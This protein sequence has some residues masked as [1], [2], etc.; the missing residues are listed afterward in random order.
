MA[1][2]TATGDRLQS[3]DVNSGK[4]RGELGDGGTEFV[5]L[6]YT[7]DGRLLAAT[8]QRLNLHL[9]YE[10]PQSPDFKSMVRLDPD[11]Y[12]AQF[13]ARLWDMTNQK[14]LAVPDFEGCALP[15]QIGATNDLGQTVDYV[16]LL[17][18]CPQ[19][20][21]RGTN[22]DFV[23]THHNAVYA[24]VKGREV[25]IIERG[26]NKVLHV[27]KGH[28]NISR[29]AFSPDGKTLAVGDFG[30]MIRLWNV[31]AGRL[32]L[33]IPAHPSTVPGVALS[34]VTGLAFRG[35]GRVLAS[36]NHVEIRLWR[37]ETDK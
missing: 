30:G 2:F 19:S 36:C 35:D 8:T 6:A 37:A 25:R 15:S 7:T 14:E 22:T 18:T 26:S 23:S 32:L 24:D 12:N 31:A 5:N 20:L 27:L 1:G 10:R 4:Q 17:L 34:P 16:V 3:W 28:E 9:P 21:S 33:T 13:R 29:V 11:A